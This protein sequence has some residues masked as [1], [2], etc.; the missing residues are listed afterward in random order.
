MFR[1]RIDVL[2]FGDSVVI[3]V[4]CW[5]RFNVTITVDFFQTLRSSIGGLLVQSGFIDW[6]LGQSLDY[7][8]V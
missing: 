6:I 3:E 4:V 1:A 7:P 8:G 5:H 2:L